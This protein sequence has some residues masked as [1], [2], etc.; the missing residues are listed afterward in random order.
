MGKLTPDKR[1]FVKVDGGYIPKEYAERESRINH[2]INNP[3]T[4]DFNNKA[5]IKKWF[6]EILMLSKKIE[7]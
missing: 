1:K 2:L 3:P 6:K 7:K 5:E 4:F